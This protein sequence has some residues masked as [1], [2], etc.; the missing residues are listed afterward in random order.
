[1]HETPHPARSRRGLWIPAAAAGAVA[2]VAFAL[3]GGGPE[4]L[5]DGTVFVVRKGPLT[6]SVTESGTIKNREQVVVKNEVE[7]RAAILTLV[8]E[9]TEVKAGDL[10][11]QLDSSR[12]VDEKSSQ[13]ITVTNSEAAHVRAR[14]N[15]AVVT[16][17]AESDVAK[18]EL[19]LKFAALDLKKYVE[20]EYPQELQSAEAAITI[21][22]EEVQRAADKLE[23][24]KRLYE[25][26]YLSLTELQAD[27]LA[28][29]KAGLDLELA[30]GKRKLLEE[31]SRTRMIEEL[32]SNLEQAGRALERAKRKASADVVQAKAELTARESEALRQK[33]KL[34]KLEEQIRKCRIEAPVAGMVVYATTGQ[35]GW[36]GNS[37]PLAEGQEVRERQELIYLPTASSM[38]AEVKIHETSLD[39]VRQ[40]LPVRITVDAVP[41]AVFEGRVAKIAPLPDAQSVWLNPDLKVYNSEVVLEGNAS[42][43]RSGMSCRAEIFVERYETAVYLPVQCVVRVAGKPTVYLADG[44]AGE[45]REVEIGLDNNSMV[46][47]LRGLVGGERVLNNP[48]LGGSVPDERPEGPIPDI[49]AKPGTSGAEKQPAPKKEAEAPGSVDWAAM[50][51]EERRKR[52]DAMTPEERQA[53]LDRMQ[54]RREQPPEG[55]GSR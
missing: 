25:Q 17:Q 9:G 42:A 41:G 6:I 33:S 11:V 50:T 26:R 45:A 40:E 39:K 51:P 47:V 49:P 38:M 54:R 1:M 32:E 2:L 3:S 52:M 53:L 34:T 21:A 43:L 15:L 28:Y 7:G 29:K 27:E 5:E 8:Q 10:L 14:E 24:S 35:S 13:I 48:P 55:G 36:R 16:S 18:A 20:G 19:D 31:F 30:L 23:W 46:H 12:L 22:R 37:E 44:G 4:E